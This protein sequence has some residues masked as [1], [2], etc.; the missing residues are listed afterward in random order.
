MGFELKGRP[1]LCYSHPLK[2][3]R[4]ITHLNVAGK[5]GLAMTLACTFM[6]NV[7]VWMAAACVCKA[8]YASPTVPCSNYTAGWWWD[9]RKGVGTG[10]VA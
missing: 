7:T 5:M 4:S 3:H 9:E 10:G 8:S 1:D 6:H 2:C